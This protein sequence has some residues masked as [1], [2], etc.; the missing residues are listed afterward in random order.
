MR[1][2]RHTDVTQ[3]LHRASRVY[4]ATS[5]YTTSRH[6]PSG[7]CPPDTT[8]VWSEDP[9]FSIEYEWTLHPVPHTSIVPIYYIIQKRW[10]LYNNLPHSIIIGLCLKKYAVRLR[11]Y[12]SIVL[13]SLEYF[14][15][16]I[17]FDW[18]SVGVLWWEGFQK[19]DLFCFQTIVK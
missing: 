14:L 3:I 7:S 6:K 13:N 16:K 18:L 2:T 10:F 5:I 15:I 12:I 17:S 4:R 9:P 11:P 8:P 1:A 19:K